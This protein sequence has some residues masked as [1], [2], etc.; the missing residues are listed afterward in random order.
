MA[1]QAQAI[2]AHAEP[3]GKFPHADIQAHQ[4]QA[5]HIHAADQ[6]Y[7]VDGRLQQVQG[8][9]GAACDFVI[10]RYDARAEARILEQL[11]EFREALD[12]G[13]IE[14][15]DALLG[16]G[17]AHARTQPREH[18]PAIV[19]AALVGCLV[20]RERKRDPEAAVAIGGAEIP[21]HH[22]G[23]AISEPAEAHLAADRMRITGE[24][25]AP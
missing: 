23:D 25:L 15:I 12:E 9:A 7:N 16:G 21:R 14:R 24:H 19:V 8:G 22:A 13:A 3:D 5:G 17:G 2:G 20:G 18:C 11:T 6:E 10:Q 1:R 4:H